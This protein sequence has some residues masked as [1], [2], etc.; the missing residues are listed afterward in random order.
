MAKRE[1]YYINDDG[2]ETGPLTN[3]QLKGL[4][5]QQVLTPQTLVWSQGMEEWT[6]AGRFSGFQ[7]LFAQRDAQTSSTASLPPQAEPQPEPQPEPAAEPQP[8][9]EDEVASFLD[10]VDQPAQ[11]A[12]DTDSPAEFVSGSTAGSS[13]ECPHC[14]QPTAVGETHC[15]KCGQ[16]LV[17][18]IDDVL[19]DLP[20]T[21]M[22]GSS[23]SERPPHRQTT[24]TSIKWILDVR[25]LLK[26]DMYSYDNQTYPAV[27]AGMRLISTL[28]KFAWLF[29][30]AI[31]VLIPVVGV[32]GSGYGF[33][34]GL[35]SRQEVISYNENLQLKQIAEIEERRDET[36]SPE[37]KRQLD[38]SLKLGSHE[39]ILR[40]AI[41]AISTIEGDVFVP[42]ELERSPRTVPSIFGGL[43]FAIL[44]V[45]LACLIALVLYIANNIQFVLS[46]AGCEMVVIFCDTEHNVRPG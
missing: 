1:W 36:D 14:G 33:I 15:Q 20:R 28:S 39:E 27:A 7:R 18:S 34:A 24:N 43:F 13:V 26:S 3:Q 4:A 16:S 2:Q 5:E 29:W 46:I 10:A 22:T 35:Q 40:E 8:T 32:L 42:W 9:S 12:I 17:A 6:P 23:N 25:K 44:Y 19:D 41:D 21:Q 30:T 38:A 11:F 31:A 45:L 37:L